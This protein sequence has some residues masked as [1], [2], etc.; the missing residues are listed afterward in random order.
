MKLD[1]VEGIRRMCC[2]W[3][4]ALRDCKLVAHKGQGGD[5]GRGGGVETFVRN[6]SDAADGRETGWLQG[7]P[8]T[9]EDPRSALRWY[10]PEEYEEANSI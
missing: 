6:G 8:E 7:H 4:S 10:S 3:P 5:D 1:T 9:L 2:F